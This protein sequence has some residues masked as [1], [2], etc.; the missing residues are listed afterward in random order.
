MFVKTGKFL[1]A[2]EYAKK[3]Q[4]HSNYV[5]DVKQVHNVHSDKAQPLLSVDIDKEIQILTDKFKKMND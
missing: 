5:Y 2:Y 3:M 1:E 4:Y